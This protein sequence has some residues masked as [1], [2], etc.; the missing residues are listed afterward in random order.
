M[1]S[2]CGTCLVEC[3]QVEILF[4]I[5]NSNRV[6][7]THLNIY[8]VHTQTRFGCGAGAEADLR[9]Q[10]SQ[11]NLRCCMLFVQVQ[12]QVLSCSCITV[13]MLCTSCHVC[14]CMY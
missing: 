3:G 11:S 10:I 4:N 12:D 14:I 9:S 13:V 5:F 7:G 2:S 8:S 1:C 6:P